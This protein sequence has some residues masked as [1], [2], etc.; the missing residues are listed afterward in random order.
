M[1]VYGLKQSGNH[2]AHGGR[3]CHSDSDRHHLGDAE[4]E[5]TTL[6]GI[7]VL[8]FALTAGR[9]PALKKPWEPCEAPKSWGRGERIRAAVYSRCSISQSSATKS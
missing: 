9:H 6:H 5:I 7:R 4:E 2:C 3:R 1:F 8:W